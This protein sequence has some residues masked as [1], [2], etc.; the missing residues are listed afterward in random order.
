MACPAARSSIGSAIDGALKAL[1]VGA[2][3]IAAPPPALAQTT[4][5]DASLETLI[6]DAAT[7]DPDTWAKAQDIVVQEDSAAAEAVHE[8]VEALPAIVMSDALPA[9]IDARRVERIGVGVR[10]RNFLTRVL[11][12]FRR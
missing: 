3:L 7:A 12:R 11:S 4:D 10:I 1:L 8:I 2:G 5:P 9:V 6:P